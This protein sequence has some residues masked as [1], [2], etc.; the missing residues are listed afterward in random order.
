MPNV[1]TNACLKNNADTLTSSLLQV[2]ISKDMAELNHLNTGVFIALFATLNLTLSM[3]LCFMQVLR[4]YAQTSN[5]LVGINK[6][7]T[8]STSCT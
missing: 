1:H 7:N 8:T 3:R 6:E 5:A 2:E 4:L